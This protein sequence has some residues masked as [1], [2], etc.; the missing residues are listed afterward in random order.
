MGRLT[1]LLSVAFSAAV[2]PRVFCEDQSPTRTG[3]VITAFAHGGKFKML[4]DC[5]QRP[6]SV[7][8]KG[9]L[10]IVYNGDAEPS[11]S[12]KGSAYPM[13]IS[14]HAESRTFSNPVRL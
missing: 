14:Y 6:Q 12:G 1:L 7:L 4:Y 3:T 2:L 8:L 11:K 5:R 13:L 9:R 10:F